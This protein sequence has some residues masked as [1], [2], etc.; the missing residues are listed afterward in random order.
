VSQTEISKT[1][2]DAGG[3]GAGGRQLP[4]T[5]RALRHR[6]FQLF[7]SGQ[8][9]S[10]VGTWMQNIAQSWLVYRLTGSSLWL[11]AIGFA[12]Q[13]PVFLIAP[14]GGVAADRHDR[15]R[16]VIGTQIS[17][18][19]LALILAAL[20]LSGRVQK[21]HIFVLATLLGVVN[22][23]DIPARQSFL[24]DMV[25][26][27]D[28]MNA[29]ALNSSMFNGARIIG[30]AIAG[31]LVATIGEGWCFFAN[32]ASYVAVIIGLMLMRVN[33]SRK[34]A[35]GA[36][37]LGHMA[38]G[39]RFVIAAAPIRTL[40]LLLGLV[41]L[42]AMPY[43]V[44]MPVFADRI[45]HGG[46]RGLGILMGATGVGAM[47]G[48]LTLASRSGLRGLGKW[49]AVSCGGFGF[50]LIL[51]SLSRNFWLSTGLLV[52]VGFCMMLEMS[53]S[54]TL[55]Q[56]MVP[57]ELRGRVMAVYSMMFMGMA[58]FGA[59]IAGVLADRVGAPLTVALGAIACVGGA[60]L[61]GLRLPD[62]RV[63]ARQ[64]ILA[65]AAAGGEPSE[66]IT[67]PVSDSAGR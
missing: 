61:F 54:N 28:L 24:V 47:L 13:I 26:K 22:A 12:G 65:Q 32:G 35:S 20:T 19:I 15:Q 5:L 56:A 67:T 29:I 25:G 4:V 60:I 14:L 58:P 17:S 31:V 27:D 30:P 42:V 57:D 46:A 51:F 10:L 59:L 21:W 2:N 1:P 34:P 38:E 7:F 53:S 23:F 9:I 45:L 43:T 52:P 55:I 66:E 33:T 18:M 48:A 40:L 11:G 44:L 62:L 16:V 37:P 3:D 64:M 39:F 6:N 41:S 8:L 50:S 63:E 49:I 36:S